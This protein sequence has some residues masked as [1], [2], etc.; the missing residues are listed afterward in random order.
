MYINF[1]GNDE[2]EL[3]EVMMGAA[4]CIHVDMSLAKKL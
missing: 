4:S 1:Q 3:P 2:R